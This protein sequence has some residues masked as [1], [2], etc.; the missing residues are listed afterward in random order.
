M[1][2]LEGQEKGAPLRLVLVDTKVPDGTAFV[3]FG[4]LDVQAITAQGLGRPSFLL[5]VIETLSAAEVEREQHDTLVKDSKI[6]VIDGALADIANPPALLLPNTDYTLHV[7][8]E[9][10]ICGED[11]SVSSGATWTPGGGQDFHFRTDGA[12]LAPNDCAVAV[13]NSLSPGPSDR[14]CQ[15]GACAGITA[16]VSTAGRGRLCSL[17]KDC[18][19]RR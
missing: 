2:Y 11:G 14:L 6:T 3:Q 5:G 15:F 19:T 16:T 7:A 8:W 17:V 13:V 10:T 18:N 12:P 4:V 1:T 9:W